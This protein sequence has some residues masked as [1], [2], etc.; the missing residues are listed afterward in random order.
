MNIPQTGQ[1]ISTHCTAD[2]KIHNLPTG[3]FSPRPSP[4]ASSNPARFHSPTPAFPTLFRTR[5]LF[6]SHGFRH[7]F[8][9]LQHPPPHIPPQHPRPD[10]HPPP[11]S[12]SPHAALCSMQSGRRF[13]ALRTHSKKPPHFASKSTEV[14]IKKCGTFG[15]KMPH[16]FSGSSDAR[17][18]LVRTT[19][20]QRLHT[21]KGMRQS[22]FPTMGKRMRKKR[23]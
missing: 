5:R 23:E 17:I 18:S 13:R 16:F 11:S 20:P 9:H 14:R 12:F 1:D 22:G 8:Q 10:F 15:V 21:A 2:I 19:I 4:S 3:A 6:I 7:G